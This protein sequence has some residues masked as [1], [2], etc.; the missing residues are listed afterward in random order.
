MGAIATGGVEVRNEE[1]IAHLQISGEAFA[2]VTARETEELLRRELA[3]RDGRPALDV[4]GRV[5]ILVDDGLATGST[6]RAAAVAVRQK[7]PEE[8]VVA[9]PT[10]PHERLE[11]LRPVSDAVLAALMPDPF[12]AVG[13][14]YL[15]FSQTSDDEVRRLILAAERG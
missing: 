12:I 4:S 7:E 5:V 9:V 13:E 6:M 14:S 2:A 10:A 3:Y 8:V 15:D 11:L 1:V